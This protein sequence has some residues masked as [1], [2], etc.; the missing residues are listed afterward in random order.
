MIHNA[1]TT[2]MYADTDQAFKGRRRSW[3]SF[4]AI[5]LTCVMADH[6]IS[7]RTSQVGLVA[8]AAGVMQDLS[9][10]GACLDAR[11]VEP[12]LVNRWVCDA[13]VVHLAQ[14]TGG[15]VMAPAERFRAV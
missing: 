4:F 7:E 5:L 1:A 8:N 9:V 12:W 10:C 2:R 11:K 14:R 13:G 3:C 6:R 15:S